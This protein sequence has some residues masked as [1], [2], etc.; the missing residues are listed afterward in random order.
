MN[1]QVVTSKL[2]KLRLSGALQ[3]FEHQSKLATYHKLDFETRLSEMLDSQIEFNSEK[4]IRTLRK[5]ARLRY[6]TTYISDINYEL[7]PSLK[8]NQISQLSTGDWIKEH[9]HLLIVGPTGM[10]KTTLACAIAQEA[11]KQHIPVVFY[12]L[13]TLLLELKAAQKEEKLKQLLRK[14]NRVPLLILDDWGNALMGKDERHLFFELIESRDLN[15]SLLITSQYP[16]STWHESFQDS[17]IADSVLD[18]I[19]H[20]AHKIE[21]KGE[22]I[23]KLNGEKM[24]KTTNKGNSHA[25]K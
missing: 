1:K 11:I 2:E 10:G 18:R 22:S 12:R 14:V 25:V 20:N 8:S 6:P 5:Q 16:V 3:S 7:Y 4:R 24:L 9:H 17:T 15:S 23:R 21:L 13:A 19:V